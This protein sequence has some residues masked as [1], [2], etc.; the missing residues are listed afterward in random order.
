MWLAVLPDNGLSHPAISPQLGIAVTRRAPITSIRAR[1]ACPA[2]QQA[3]PSD[4]VNLIDRCRLLG[5]AESKQG[6]KGALFH[7]AANGQWTK[8]ENSTPRRF[9]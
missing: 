6:R 9:A 2:R 3:L 1:V 7:F 4:P 8:V 5:L